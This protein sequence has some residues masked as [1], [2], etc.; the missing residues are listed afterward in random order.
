MRGKIIK[1]KMAKRRA[2]KRPKKQI[3]GK[4][5]GMIDQLRNSRGSG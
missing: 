4:R 3:S 2:E 5:G 1:K